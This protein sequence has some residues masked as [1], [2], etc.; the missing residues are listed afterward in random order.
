M[1]FAG[2]M[3]QMV[4]HRVSDSQ[5]VSAFIAIFNGVEWLEVAVNNTTFHSSVTGMSLKL[6][7]EP[8]DNNRQVRL[9]QELGEAQRLY[10]QRRI[11]LGAGI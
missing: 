3:Y 1:L 4:I 2:T 7:S 6:P 11:P 5:I 10:V 8:V 9:S